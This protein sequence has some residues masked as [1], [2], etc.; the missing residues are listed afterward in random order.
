MFLIEVSLLEKQNCVLMGILNRR[1]RIF[2]LKYP[3][4]N[5]EK[6]VGEV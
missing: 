6:R 5:F 3:I 2:F 4:Y 1:L